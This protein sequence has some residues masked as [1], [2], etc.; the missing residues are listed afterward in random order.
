[1]GAACVRAA[2]TDGDG[3]AAAGGDTP[4]HSRRWSNGGVG[5]S[6]AA[7]GA[8]A[9]VRQ[10]DP[11]SDWE[12][13]TDA[14]KLAAAAALPPDVIQARAATAAD[15]HARPKTHATPLNVAACRM[16]ATT[17]LLAEGA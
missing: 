9:P 10:A 3:D 7:G 16:R 15:T 1:M 14:A 13:L 17:A 5:G 2:H 12:L 11:S 8:V 4:S 6:S